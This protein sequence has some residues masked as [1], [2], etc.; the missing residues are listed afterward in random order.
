VKD[1]KILCIGALKG[2][3]T[4]EREIDAQGAYVTPGGVDTVS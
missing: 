1:G 2:V 4:A 3:F